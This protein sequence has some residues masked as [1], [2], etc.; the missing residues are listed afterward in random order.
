MIP[1]I[2]AGGA[3]AVGPPLDI[4]SFSFNPSDKNAAIT[5]SGGNKVATSTSAA[6]HLYAACDSAKNSGA[7]IFEFEITSIPASTGNIGVG[8]ADVPAGGD[9]T[10]N[11]YPGV[12]TGF[13][14]WVR[15]SG[16][17]SRFYHNAS[18]Y[19]SLSTSTQSFSA[20]DVITCTVDLASKEC[21]VYRN[22]SLIYT[23]TVS[24]INTG[25]YS[26]APV[27]K[28]WGTATP[29]TVTIPASITY[30]VAGFS[31]WA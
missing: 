7:W 3:N 8:L 13:Q 16:A 19:D 29:A 5:L 14:W 9:T 2:V 26:Y 20:G 11:S 15:K 10:N 27:V 21:K 28:L 1:G 6:S 23:K 30:P 17:L 18:T 24:N 4:Q 12:R 31:P 25:T 22:G